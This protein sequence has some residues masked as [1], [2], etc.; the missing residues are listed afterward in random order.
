MV[1]YKYSEEDD[2]TVVEESFKYNCPKFNFLDKLRI[3]FVKIMN[4]ICF[5]ILP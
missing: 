2:I 5:I 3:K 4:K 1:K